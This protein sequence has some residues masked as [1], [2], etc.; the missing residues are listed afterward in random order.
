MSNL[1][2]YKQARA[3]LDEQWGLEASSNMD[4]E[5]DES[6]NKA[7]EVWDKNLIKWAEEV[8]KFTE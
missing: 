6:K 3:E 4:N 1:S 2:K 7:W 5:W 8:A